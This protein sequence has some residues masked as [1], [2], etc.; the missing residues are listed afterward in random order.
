MLVFV[1]ARLNRFKLL[2]AQ[3]L[4]QLCLAA[5][6][7]AVHGAFGHVKHEACFCNARIGQSGLQ[8]LER[9]LS[10]RAFVDWAKHLRQLAFGALDQHAWND[11]HQRQAVAPGQTGDGFFFYVTKASLCAFNLVHGPARSFDAWQTGSGQWQAHESSG[12]Q[13][14][15]IQI[16]V[17]IGLIHVLFDGLAQALVACS[18]SNVCGSSSHRA[19]LRVLNGAVGNGFQHPCARLRN[20]DHGCSFCRVSQHPCK[21]KSTANAFTKCAAVSFRCIDRGP[22]AF[23]E[24][25]GQRSDL[26]LL[27]TKTLA[28]LLGDKVGQSKQGAV[29]A[30]G[31]IVD[32]ALRCLA[33][34]NNA[35]GARG[36]RVRSARVDL[37]RRSRAFLTLDHFPRQHVNKFALGVGQHW[38]YWFKAR[39]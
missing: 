11:V 27:H 12:R 7:G 23:V 33:F 8:L 24:E 37:R 16:L 26:V 32:Q 15:F 31:E 10:F 5:E 21:G 2:G 9:L 25:L 17:W 36:P 3:L 22:L 28:N 39:S 35:F 13:E 30:P 38:H 20:L 19:L 4:E 1:N 14:V 18:E 6:Q 34:R 29:E